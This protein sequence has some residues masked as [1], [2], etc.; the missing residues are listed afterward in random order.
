MVIYF[1]SVCP[2]DYFVSA[3]LVQTRRFQL[4]HIFYWTRFFVVS[5]EQFNY[6]QNDSIACSPKTRET[7]FFLSS[8]VQS[9]PCD[10]LQEKW[11]VHHK[12]DYVHPHKYLFQ[13]VAVTKN[14]LKS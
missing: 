14:T 2:P 6:L 9:T 7:P 12:K 4:P 10:T 5:E 3:E 13:G 8:F 1:C 11:A